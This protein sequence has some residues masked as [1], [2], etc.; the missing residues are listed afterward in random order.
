MRQRAPP[1]RSPCISVYFCSRIS[2]ACLRVSPS[3]PRVSA[4]RI[5]VS[6]YACLHTVHT[7]IIIL[8]IRV[9][10]CRSTALTRADTSLSAAAP[11]PG[12]SERTALTVRIPHEVT[13]PAP[14]V[15]GSEPQV[16]GAEAE[17]TWMLEPG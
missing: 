13:G 4:S 16:T 6:T 12:G 9:S 1:Q 2:V 5:Y 7:R 8:Y 17:V 10:P 11:V 14:P 15:T 3:H